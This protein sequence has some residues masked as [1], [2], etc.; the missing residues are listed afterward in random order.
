MTSFTYLFFFYT[1]DNLADP[2]KVKRVILVCGKHYYELH[3]ERVNARIDDVA[4]VRVEALAPFPL[5]DLQREL[6]RYPNARSKLIIY[7]T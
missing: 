3:K 4:I 2:K 1:G 6:E 5:Q 7:F